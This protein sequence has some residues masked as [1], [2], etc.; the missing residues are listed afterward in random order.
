M[1]SH[2][3]PNGKIVHSTVARPYALVHRGKARHFGSL[4]AA[5]RSAVPGSHI[6]FDYVPGCGLLVEHV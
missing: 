2:T 5:R 6:F 3:F 4:E 1:I